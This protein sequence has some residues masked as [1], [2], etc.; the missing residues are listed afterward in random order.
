MN[1]RTPVLD[2]DV[3]SSQSLCLGLSGGAPSSLASA[4]MPQPESWDLTF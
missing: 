1:P 4:E 2:T 3:G